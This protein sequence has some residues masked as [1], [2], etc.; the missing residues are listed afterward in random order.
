MTN[1]QLEHL[2]RIRTSFARLVTQKFFKGAQ[3]HGG[4]LQD[5][6]VLDL[7]DEALAECLDQFTFLWTLREKLAGETFDQPPVPDNSGAPTPSLTEID[8][9]SN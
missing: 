2:T 1:R 6:P 8:C 4:D 9:D 3:E 5:R 7:V